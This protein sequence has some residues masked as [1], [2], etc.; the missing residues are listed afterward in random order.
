MATG[1]LTP[2]CPAKRAGAQIIDPRPYAVGEIA[3]AY[4]KYPHI[5]D[6]L[7]ALGYADAQ[8]ADLR[9]T[10]ERIPCDAVLIATPVDLSRVVSIEQPTVRVTYSF[11]ERGTQYISQLLRKVFVEHAS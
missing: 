5:R 11:E 6:V 10:I 3:E 7:P 9:S 1:C 8:L 4:E 2:R